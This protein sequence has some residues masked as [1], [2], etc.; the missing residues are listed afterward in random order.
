MER[1]SASGDV[2]RAAMSSF[3]GSA[4][5]WYDFTI[6]STAAA[7]VFGSAFFPAGDPTTQSLLAFAT[8]G[9][10]FL[11]RPLGGAVA[12]HLGDRLGRKTTL[13]LTLSIMGVATAAIG[14]L[15]TY[16][17]AG[18]VAP[19]LLVV[20]RL[21]QGFSAGGEWAGAALMAVEHAPTHRRGLWGSFVQSGTPFGV[22]LAILVFLAVQ[23]GLGAD[24]FVAWGWRVPFLLS[25]VLL[26]LAMYIRL[27]V[28]ESPVFVAV[29]K[30]KPTRTPLLRVFR[31]RPRQLVIAALTF[32]GCN[33]IG[34]VFLSFLL[35][36]GTGV[37]RLD[38][39]TILLVSLV[40]GVAWCGANIV[41]GAL[42][43]R[44]GRRSIY[45]VGYLLFAAWAF[46]FFALVNTAAPLLMC[47]AV[48]VLCIA[49]GL[50]FG[51]QAALFAELFPPAFR[52]SGASLA[53]AIGSILGGAF[54]PLIATF[55]LAETGTVFAV[56]SY[57]A[58][59]AIISLVA[60]LALRER[61]L[62]D[63]RAADE[64]QRAVSA[65]SGA[66][67]PDEAGR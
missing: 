47:L 30:A 5:E 26:G 22:I 29:R 40:G 27:R 59:V 44:L 18:L 41:G 28:A 48:A 50:T 32:V 15:P 53:M 42:A 25:F 33:A 23:I 37:L 7:L 10:G 61:E 20:C 24:A 2:R 12:G 31:E 3:L 1:Q 58:A 14:L 9:I 64:R 17:Q 13:L 11:A 49:I 62:G 54:A 55:L 19:V 6:F 63:M 21:V 60:V 65:R 34:Y 4:I 35:A 43:D 57:M 66:P 16:G 46:P 45:V 67:V 51:P 8:L 39:G 52:Y 38:R 56:S 36:Y